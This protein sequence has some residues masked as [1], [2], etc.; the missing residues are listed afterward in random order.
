MLKL[1]VADALVEL[2]GFA[3][4]LRSWSD[5]LDE[6]DGLEAAAAASCE[7]LLA[8]MAQ[9][10]RLDNKEALALALFVEGFVGKTLPSGATSGGFA[11]Y[12]GAFAR[13]VTLQLLR[14]APAASLGPQLV[15]KLWPAVHA[16]LKRDAGLQLEREIGGKLK[17]VWYKLKPSSS[18]KKGLGAFHPEEL[19]AAVLQFLVTHLQVS[20]ERKSHELG[21]GLG[22]RHPAEEWVQEVLDRP[23]GWGV[24]VPLL[25]APL[26]AAQEATDIGYA[27]RKME[28]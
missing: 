16:K 4:F 28:V 1:F 27:E 25:V 5:M 11:L 26:P 19:I 17:M 14:W 8:L 22:P 15:G 2:R 21:E 23:F 3:P 12:G 13:R 18:L 9:V 24:L 10:Q 7:V 20:C 6:G